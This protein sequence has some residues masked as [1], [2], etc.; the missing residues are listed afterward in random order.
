MPIIMPG[1]RRDQTLELVPF[2][3]SGGYKVISK[4]AAKVLNGDPWMGWFG[5][6]E[7]RNETFRVSDV[8]F[9]CDS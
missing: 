2:H 5:R 6:P 9:K 1:G 3:R 4:R 7:R 8:S